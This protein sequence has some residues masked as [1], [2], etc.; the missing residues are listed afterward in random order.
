M[1]KDMITVGLDIGTTKVVVIVGEKHANGTLRILGLGQSPSTGVDKGAIQNISK[2]TDAIRAAVTMAEQS[3]GYKINRVT[4]GIAGQYIRS[5]RQTEYI[6][7]S[8][9]NDVIRQEDLDALTAKA[10][11]LPISENET[12][13]HILPQE[14]RVDNQSGILEPIG[15]A[16]RRLEA[17]FHIVIGQIAPLQNIKRCVEGAGLKLAGVCLQPMASADAVLS[18]DEKEA[19][20]VMV[21]IGG[22]T[23]DLVIMKNSLVRHSAVL[24][25]GGNAITEDIIEACSILKRN[26]ELL[27]REYGSTWPGENSDTD[28]VSIP[29]MQGYPSKEISLKDLSKVVY[30]RMDEILDSINNEINNYHQIEPGRQLIGG[31]VLTGGGA[32]LRHLQPFA[33]YKTGMNSRIGLPNVYVEASE[34][35]DIDTPMYSTCIGLL[36]SAPDGQY[37]ES[38][39]YIDEEEEVEVPVYNT[40]DDTTYDGDDDEIYGDE[41]EDE[42]EEIETEEEDV[43]TQTSVAKTTSTPSAPK[44]RKTPSEHL[45]FM[46]TLKEKTEKKIED[47]STRTNKAILDFLQKL[48]D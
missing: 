33:H 11:A 24:P 38:P 6:T 31:V 41:Y 4:V 19:G 22:G 39:S 44:V 47:V 46:K 1:K 12:I 15:M 9:V 26:A 35:F 34:G 21:D 29:V 20:V 7:R 18:A 13:L 25:L 17:T 48:G 27:K 3:S 10:A 30:A 8:A 5:T 16:G 23:T 45:S 37:V 32:L 14:Y 43:P 42:V 36:L 28:V 40:A 2:T